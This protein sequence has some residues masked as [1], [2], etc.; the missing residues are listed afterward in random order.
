[1]YLSFCVGLCVFST[2]KSKGLIAASRP[3]NLHGPLACCSKRFPC[4]GRPFRVS[5]TG[6]SVRREDYYTSL[7]LATK[8]REKAAVLLVKSK[9]TFADSQLFHDAAALG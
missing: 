9:L 8:K 3:S 6:G 4:F 2:G 7:E 5:K 1:L